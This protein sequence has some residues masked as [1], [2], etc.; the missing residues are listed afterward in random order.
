MI[1]QIILIILLANIVFAQWS[2]TPENP[3]QITDWGHIGDACT[4]GDGGIFIAIQ[5]PLAYPPWVQ[6]LWVQRVDKYG[7]IKWD[8]PQRI[9]GHDITI[10]YNTTKII[11]SEKGSAIVVYSEA[12]D[13]IGFLPAPTYQPVFR[14][15]IYANKIDSLGNLLWGEKGIKIIEVDTAQAENFTAVADDDGGVYVSYNSNLTYKYNSTDKDT[16]KSYLQHISKNGEKLFDGGGRLLYEGVYNSGA[17]SQYLSKRNPDGIFL[18]YYKDQNYTTA[19]IES[20]NR[21]ETIEWRIISPRILSG[22]TSDVKGGGAWSIV[23]YM[24]SIYNVVAYRIDENGNLTWGEDGIVVYKDVSWNS[25]AQHLEFTDNEKLFVPFGSRYQII[26]SSGDL[27]FPNGGENISNDLNPIYAHGIINNIVVWKKTITDSSIGFATKV[28]S[29]G[30]KEWEA[31]YSLALP[32]GG[33]EISD[34][35]GGIIAYWENHGVFLQQINKYGE[36]GKV[37]TNVKEGN[38]LVFP[39]FELQQNY[40]NPF[41]RSTII[42][43]EI[44]G[45]GQKIQNVKLVVYNILGQEVAVLFSKEQKSG[46]YEVKFDASNLPSGI[47]YIQLI[48]SNKNKIIKSIY[49]K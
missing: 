34:G 15:H 17:S 18:A 6:T 4:D 1:K 24:D 16:I 42:R 45:T 5:A 3:L 36:L 27:F 39:K 33:Y 43:Y 46:N 41:N 25:F 47:Y 2:T 40:P 9:E 38:N 7:N 26:E 20:I 31:L 49:L 37:V 8:Y 29:L 14:Y 21:D 32:N 19:I 11:K 13:T 48:V 22:I 35:A 44:G 28:N 23:R 30:E 12:V 10:G